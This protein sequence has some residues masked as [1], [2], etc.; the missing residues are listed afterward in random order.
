MSFRW[1]CQDGRV[2]A[3]DE[4]DTKHI[5]N[6][7]K[8]CYN[9]LIGLHG[10]GERVWFT[11][12]WRGHAIAAA[13]APRN[14]MQKIV[15]FVEEIERRGDLPQQYQKPYNMIVAQLAKLYGITINRIVQKED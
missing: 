2:L 11:K 5:F 9:H 1:R 4:M 10:L 13:I 8:M 6:S 14:Y 3:L 15:I 7:M 12:L